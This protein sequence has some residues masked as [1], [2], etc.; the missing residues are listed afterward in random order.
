[1]TEKIER[2]YVHPDFKKLM[3]RKAKVEN[4]MSLIKYSK[5]LADNFEREDI[6][7]RE[8]EVKKRRKEKD[9]RFGL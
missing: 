5:I 8:L 1:M 4:S 2:I 7:K 6:F 3:F 9:F